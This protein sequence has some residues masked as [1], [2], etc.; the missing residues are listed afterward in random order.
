MDFR[1]L[2]NEEL[3]NGIAILAAQSGFESHANHSSFSPVQNGIRGVEWYMGGMSQE[4]YRGLKS[5]LLR[6]LNGGR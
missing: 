3:I 5:E 1:H 6:R 4:R 2:S